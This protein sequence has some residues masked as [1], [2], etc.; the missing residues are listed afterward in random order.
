MPG[1]VVGARGRR[2]AVGLRLAC[3]RGGC[4]GCRSRSMALGAGVFGSKGAQMCLVVWMSRAHDVANHSGCEP[5]REGV[6]Q[7]LAGDGTIE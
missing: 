4:G 5:G 3:P 7:C 1:W 2:G 6:R